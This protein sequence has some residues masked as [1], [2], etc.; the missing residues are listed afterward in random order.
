MCSTDCAAAMIFCRAALQDNKG[1]PPA[2]QVWKVTKAQ[3]KFDFMLL[4]RHKSNDL[5]KIHSKMIK[6]SD[7]FVDYVYNTFQF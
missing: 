2:S 4:Q 6:M 1:T 7:F 3:R 5:F